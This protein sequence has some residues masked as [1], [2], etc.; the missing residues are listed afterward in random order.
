MFS[1][2]GFGDLGKLDRMFRCPALVR[3]PAGNLVRRSGGMGMGG[4]AG[5][6]RGEAIGPDAEAGWVARVRRALVDWYESGH[7]DLPWR[8]DR[9][10]YRILVSESMLVQ[11][12]V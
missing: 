7:R 3:G 4:S 2:A 10:P 8:A 5:A 9:D 12:T 6:G 1:K 11:T